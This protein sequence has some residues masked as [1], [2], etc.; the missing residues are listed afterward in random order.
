MINH[1][2]ELKQPY[3][4]GTIQSNPL[5]EEIYARHKNSAGYLTKREVEKL[6]FFPMTGPCYRFFPVHIGIE[7][8]R[9]HKTIPWPAPIEQIGRME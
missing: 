9:Y 2:V 3:V 7:E 5:S 6:A 8:F 1:P 4:V